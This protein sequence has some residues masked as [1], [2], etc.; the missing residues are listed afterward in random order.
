MYKEVIG[1]TTATNAII[2]RNIKL[3][4]LLFRCVEVALALKI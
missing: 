2:M 3:W 1:V 4:G